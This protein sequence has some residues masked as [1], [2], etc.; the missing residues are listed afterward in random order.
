VT[1]ILARLGRLLDLERPTPG[2]RTQWTVRTEHGV[3][4]VVLEQYVSGTRVRLDGKTVGH[5]P[6]WS[7]PA[8]PF[9]FAVGPLPATLGLSPDTEAGTVRATLIVDG[10][11][12]APDAPRWRLR[13]VPPTPWS[14]ILAS[15]GYALGALL[16]SAAVLGEPYQSWIVTALHVT[17]DVAWIAAVRAFDPLA[18]LPSWLAMVTASR[19]SMLVLGLSI[20]ALV[21]VAHD[22]R[23][24]GRVPVLRSPSRWERATGWAALT[25]AA[26]LVP[27]LFG[28]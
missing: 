5:S 10:A 16:V 1:T 9:R 18:L 20:A 11:R 24:R 7:F 27:L 26:L 17:L 25:L 23:L 6:A 4:V 14:R 13:P 12:I 19:A 2:E 15:A 28:A 3:Y 21:T 22:P 8:V